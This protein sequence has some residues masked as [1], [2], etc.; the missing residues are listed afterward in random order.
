MSATH[1]W[2]IELFAAVAKKNILCKPKPKQGPFSFADHALLKDVHRRTEHT[3]TSTPRRAR[4]TCAADADY[5]ARIMVS[6]LCCKAYNLLQGVTRLLAQAPLQDPPLAVGLLE[7]AVAPL[8]RPPPPS[9][10]RPSLQQALV[11]SSLSQHPQA[12]VPLTQQVCIGSTVSIDYI[13]L[14]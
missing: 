7:Q 3:N 4:A 1:T 2:K 12:S 13:L 10:L 9:S 6:V 8:V 11:N 14:V 5:N